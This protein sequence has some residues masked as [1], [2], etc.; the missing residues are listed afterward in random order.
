MVNHDLAGL[1]GRA[2][3]LFSKTSDHV[4]LPAKPKPSL[5][6]LIMGRL[7]GQ[8]YLIALDFL[9]SFQLLGNLLLN[10]TSLIQSHAGN[11]T[12]KSVF[13]CASVVKT[14]INC[15]FLSPLSWE[16]LNIW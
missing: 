16:S 10:S 5:K 15:I 8:G 4:F 11:L 9:C 14:I 12:F 6:R 3:D 13:V 7:V 2:A 1:L